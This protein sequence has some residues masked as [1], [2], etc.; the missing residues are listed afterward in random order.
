MSMIGKQVKHIKFGEGY[1]IQRTGDKIE[2]KFQEQSKIFLYP[3]GFEV[4]LKF[5][6]DEM[7]KI[8]QK[9]L[10]DRKQKLDEEQ[11]K[12][13]QHRQIITKI[14]KMKSKASTHAVFHMDETDWEEMQ[15][16]WKVFFGYYK[17]GKM[18]GQPRIPEK[19]NMNSVCLITIK[20]KDEAEES[21]Y[22]AGAFFAQED[23]IGEKCTDGWIS[24]HEKYR[25]IWTEEHEKIY[26]WSLFPEQLK[27]SKWGTGQTKFIA[28]KLMKNILFYMEQNTT[29]EVLEQVKNFNE[30]F[31]EMNY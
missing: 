25:I 18:K 28:D 7:T 6:D 4:F 30:Y 17:S 8:V 15:K 21:R 5:T 14:K 2:I 22:I 10:A 16:E 31:V 11:I 13:N 23:F 20:E 1:V 19:I 3:E 24:A 29:G 12:I 27:T 9:E 26:F